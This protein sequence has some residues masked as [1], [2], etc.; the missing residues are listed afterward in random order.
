VCHDLLVSCTFVALLLQMRTTGS[1]AGLSL[2]T[3]VAVVVCRVMHLGTR[4]QAHY[5]PWTLAPLIYLLFDV[6]N[7]TAGLVSIALFLR[8]RQTYEVE[9]DNFGMQFFDWL[10]VAPR[11]R[12]SVR[13]RLLGASF[14]YAATG[15]IAMLWS[16]VRRTGESWHF[17]FLWCFYDTLCAGAMLPQFWMFHQE[18]VVT[19]LLASFVVMIALSRVCCVVF[20]LGCISF[21][22]Y[23]HVNFHS[24]L[25]VEALNL[26]LFV[27]FLFFCAR[28]KFRG[29]T[30]IT[31]LVE[32]DKV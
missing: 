13:R 7:A 26:L 31:L 3:L 17:T 14:I 22:R 2:Q 24:Q 4:H 12:F 20:V 16:L 8:R 32:F 1:A 30:R 21:L 9:K 19:Q 18:K 28:A 11:A 15:V 25:C 6:L 27:D 10:W 29:E 5:L 23:T